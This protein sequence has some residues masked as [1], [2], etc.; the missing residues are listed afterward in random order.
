MSPMPAAS[1]I[2][3]HAT[4]AAPAP[5]TTTRRSASVRPVTRAA[6][7]SAASTTIAVPCWS[8]WKTGMSSRSR[9]RGSMS[10]QRGAEM[11]SRLMPPK[12]GAMPLDGLD[13]LVRVGRVQHDRDGVD[14][15]ELAEQRRLALH[16]RQG[17]ERADVAEPEH[18]RAVADD[19]DQPRAPGVVAGQLLV[20]VD[21]GADLG[22]PGR[23]GQRQRLAVGERQRAAHH[24]L[25]ALVHAEHRTVRI[26]PHGEAPLTI[27]VVGAEPAQ[28]TARCCW[29]LGVCPA[30]SSLARDAEP[31]KRIGH[32]WTKPDELRQGLGH[33]TTSLRGRS[34]R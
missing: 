9:S 4:P 21:R 20:L 26:E 15:G 23:V 18:G 19:G 28:V 29:S 30:A 12:D 2:F 33:R 31:P 11:S 32:I 6:L 14:P 1:R 27:G 22:D 13:D 16:H 5:D 34:V 3:V 25:A 24:Q 8:S 17:G 7:R 10:K